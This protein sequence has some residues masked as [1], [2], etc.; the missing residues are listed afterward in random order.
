MIAFGSCLGFFHGGQSLY[1]LRKPPLRKAKIA[2]CGIHAGHGI[3]HTSSLGIGTIYCYLL[4][5]LNV[6]FRQR[7]TSSSAGD[8]RA[9]RYG[10]SAATDGRR[11]QGCCEEGRSSV[12]VLTLLLDAKW[13]IGMII[14]VGLL[15]MNNHIFFL[16]FG[17]SFPPRLLLYR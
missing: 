1:S 4:S 17:L 12:D 15:L 2:Y 6:D 16:P 7:K 11:I 5:S 3:D 10:I 8:G 9:T 14:G 13:A